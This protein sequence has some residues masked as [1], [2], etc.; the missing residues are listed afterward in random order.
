[1]NLAE[2]LLATILSAPA[3][4]AGDP[5]PPVDVA[6]R[7]DAMASERGLEDC[8]WRI[9]LVDLLDLLGTDRSYE[10]R[11]RLARDLGFGPGEIE[12]RGS[13]EMNLGILRRLFERIAERGG[14]LPP[15][16]PF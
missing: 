6:A 13:A 9:C 10:A 3:A 15:D 7:L 12:S 4:E 14:K 1:M 11:R 2:E 16:L 5:A 8:E